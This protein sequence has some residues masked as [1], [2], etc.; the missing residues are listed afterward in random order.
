[1]MFL[2]IERSRIEVLQE[3]LLSC[4]GCIRRLIYNPRSVYAKMTCR[5]NKWRWQYLEANGRGSFDISSTG[6]T[7]YPVRILA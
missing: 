1:M 4:Y 6:V 7:G 2:C 5:V 3:G